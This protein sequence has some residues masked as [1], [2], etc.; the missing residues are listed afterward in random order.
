MTTLLGNKERFAVEIGEFSKGL[1]VVDLWAA[2]RWWTCDDNCAYLPQFLQSVRDTIDRLRSGADLVLPFPGLSPAE[3]YR[4]LLAAD[5]G[6]HQRFWFANWGPTTDN[7]D[8]LLFRD[9]ERVA[10]PF[11]FWRSEHLFPDEL[12]K[13]FVAELPESELLWVLEEMLK[14]LNSSDGA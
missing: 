5:D 8:A 10:I 14:V 11:E 3:A 12:G 1:R 6:S 2:N 9:G 7:V 13:T 4:R